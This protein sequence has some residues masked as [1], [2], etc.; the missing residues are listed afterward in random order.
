MFDDV[1]V[2]DGAE[3]GERGSSSSYVAFSA[4]MFVLDDGSAD[5]V[6]DGEALV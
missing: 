1:G 5:G 4:E 6:D 3:A 2:G